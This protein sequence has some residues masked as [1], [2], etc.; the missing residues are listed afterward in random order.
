MIDFEGAADAL[1]DLARPHHEVLDEELAA[2]TEQVGQGQPALGPFEDV[3]LL[4]PD[5]GQLAA[6]P[7]D[8]VTLPRV[9]L[10]PLEERLSLLQPHFP[11]GDPVFRHGVFLSPCPDPLP[12]L[13]DDERKRR[14]ARCRSR[15][16]W[17]RVGSDMPDT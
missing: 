7:A 12:Y 6:L 4:D 15:D 3:F 17:N 16:Q 2:A 1:P 14:A 9:G 8:L 5:P 11:R 10:L 13:L